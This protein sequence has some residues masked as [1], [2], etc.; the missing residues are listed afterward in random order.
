MKLRRPIISNPRGKNLGWGYLRRE[1]KN[2]GKATNPKT[3]LNQ[4]KPV[5]PNPIILSLSAAEA[6][7]NAVITK[8]RPVTKELSLIILIFSIL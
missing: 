2:S 6:A 4:R 1:S 7:R 8:K 3:K 5:E